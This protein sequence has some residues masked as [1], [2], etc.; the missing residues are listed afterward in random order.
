MLN[1]Q[2]VTL[3]N[4]EVHPLALRARAPLVE[5]NGEMNHDKRFPLYEWQR[6]SLAFGKIQPG[7]RCLE[8]GPGRGYLSNMLAWDKRFENQIA[9]D[10]VELKNPKKFDPH[11]QYVQKSVT[12]LDEPDNYYDT[13]IC[14]EVLEHLEDRDFEKALH[15]IRRVCKTHL[16]ISVP[17]LEPLPLPHYHKQQFDAARVQSTFPDGQLSLLMKTPTQKVPW[18]MIEE[19]HPQ[20]NQAAA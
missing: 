13:V 4:I 7:A 5:K 1:A 3:E 17:F 11:I 8:V 12:E 10:I 19:M 14:M 18:L 9:L 2:I 16:I 15:N 6:I 20:T